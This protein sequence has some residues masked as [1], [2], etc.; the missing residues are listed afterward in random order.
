M[1]ET[2]T[3]AGVTHYEVQKKRRESTLQW[4]REQRKFVV[5]ADELEMHDTPRRMKR[6][7]Q[8]SADGESPSLV[9]DANVH[10]IAPGE[11]STIHRHSWDAIGFVTEGSG[12][13][14]INGKRI[15][16]QPWDTFHIP[17]WSWHRHGNDVDRPARFVTWSVEPMFEML[18]AAIQEDAGDTPFDQLPPPPAQTAPLDGADPYSRRTQRL[19]EGFKGVDDARLITRFEDAPFKITPRGARSAFLVDPSLGYYTTGLTAVWHQLAPGLFQSRHRHGG[20][21][22]LYVVDG[23]G[24]T[25][26]NG[27]DYPWGPGD[28]VVVDHWAWHQHFND[29]PDNIASLIRVHNFDTLYMGMR[30]MLDDLDLFEELPK[31]DAPDISNVV[32]P[33]VE[34]GRPRS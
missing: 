2:H 16:W 15:Q 7:V 32:W 4:W 19:F 23:H 6:G 29:D 33:P 10:E 22:W 30:V 8:V 25:E 20:E 21:A 14:E 27:V 24:H 3:T 28:L 18:N 13:S 31:L 17:A 9:L 11:T 1:A 12:W 34:E 5:K 26:I